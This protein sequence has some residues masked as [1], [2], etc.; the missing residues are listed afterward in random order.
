MN[1]EDHEA[2]EAH[3]ADWGN[4]ERDEVTNRVIGLAIK[5][6]RTVGPGLLEQ[7]YED[8]LGFEL[9]RAG[10]RF[11][12]QVKLPLIYEGIRFERAYRADLI[13]EESVLLEI[14]SIES[15]LP[16]HESQILTYLRLSGCHIGLLLNFNTKLLKNGLRRFV[17]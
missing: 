4:S 7:V 12:R 5:I 9:A 8:C 13:V 3:E 1:R 10:L 14:K 6:H 15:I 11:E 16:V 2:R 17:S